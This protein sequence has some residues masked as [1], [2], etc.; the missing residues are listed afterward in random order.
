MRLSQSITNKLVA[1]VAILGI[2]I[3]VISGILLNQQTAHMVKNMELDAVQEKIKTIASE[4]DKFMLEK[5]KIPQVM[6]NTEIFRKYLIAMKGETNRKKAKTIPEYLAVYN[7]L[8][9]IKQSDTDL[10]LVYVAIN[11]NNN[12]ISEDADFEVDNDYNLQVRNW[13]TDAIEKQKIHITSP[14]VDG[15]TGE[16]VLSAVVP[17]FDKGK[18]LGVTAID[19]SIARLSQMI[20]TFKPYEDSYS[21][22]IDRKGTFVYHPEEEKILLENIIDQN[23]TL[24]NIGQDMMNGETN[25]RRYHVDDKD[26]YIAFAPIQSSDW[27]VGIFIPKKVISDKV[28]AVTRTILISFII[29]ILLLITGIFFIT[30]YYLKPTKTIEKRLQ[31]IAEGNLTQMVDIH[32]NDEFAR[33][34]DSLNVMQSSIRQMIGEISTKAEHLSASSQE[35]TATA[36][37]V[38]NATAEVAKTVDE[39]ATGAGEQAEDTT[40]VAISVEDMGNIL[41]SETEQIAR[42]NQSAQEIDHEKESGNNILR[43][44]V[45]A[46]EKSTDATESVYQ[47]IVSNNQSA[48]KIKES[49]TMIQSISD[50]TNLLALNAAIEAARAGEAGRGFAVVAEEIRK[51]AEQSNTFT[52][53]INN[54][55]LELKQKSEQAVQAMEHVKDINHNQQQHVNDTEERFHSIA[56][57]IDTINH[58]INELNH[59][60]NQ[61]SEHKNQIVNLTQSLSAVSEENAAGTQEVSATMTEQAETVKQI[62]DAGHD[63]SHI[64]EELQQLISHFKI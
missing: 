6:G 38:S 2:I 63:L 54:V 40:N 30:R 26:G 14:Y 62:A 64:A 46:T 36:N 29:G 49:S 56:S 25:I 17:I 10:G 32:S 7:S 60:S 61:M 44:L 19:I 37:V 15:Y 45:H 5:S 52:E 59:S 41:T 34:A 9:L 22:L 33:I 58:I 27:S 21:L 4:M 35:L 42:L 3:F 8:Q 13:Y 11:D 18:P 12:F 47:S 16:L 39:I 50:Q 23:T 28:A 24:S 53:E 55:I 51:L 43:E 20:S 57:S 31:A 1:V 48:E